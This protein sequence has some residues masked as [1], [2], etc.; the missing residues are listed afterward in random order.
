MKAVDFIVEFDD[1]Y[2][3]IEFKDPQNPK[4]PEEGGREFIEELRSSGLDSDLMYKY[5]DS[6]LYE[7]AS[8]RAEKPIYYL[9]LVAW[10]GLSPADLTTRT[11]ALRRLLPLDGPALGS[12]SRP[13]VADCFVFNVGSWNRN[14]PRYPLIRLSSGSQP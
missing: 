5:R 4:A 13:I 9:V 6:F 3:F 11:D 2:L 14:F 10:D 1:R 7:W 12:W 8:G